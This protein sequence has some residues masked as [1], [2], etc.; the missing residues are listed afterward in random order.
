MHSNFI[1]P[2]NA[3]DLGA[4]RQIW[5]DE[6]NGAAGSRPA[7]H[8]FFFEGWGSGKW[9]GA[10]YTKHDAYLDGT[11]TYFYGLALKDGKFMASYL[12]T[13]SWQAP[14]SQWTTL[15]PGRGRV[16]RGS[17]RR[18]FYAGPGSLERILV[19]RSLRSRMMAI[20]ATGTEID[21][22]EYIVDGGEDGC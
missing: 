11:G 5:A 1:T 22:M 4:Y 15:G 10:Y 7:P 20:P 8:W 17:D 19:I 18:D 2:A 9:R 12:Q 3:L 21:I 14:R 6:F 13:Y 16:H